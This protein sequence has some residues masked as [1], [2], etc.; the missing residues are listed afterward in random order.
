MTGDTTVQDLDRL[1]EY[2]RRSRGFD[3][4]AYKRPSLQRRIHKRMQTVGV[5]TVPEYV[6]HLEAHPD[7]FARLFD[8][9]LINVTGFLRDPPAWDALRDTVIPRIVQPR[10]PDEP[11]RV[12]SAGSASGEEAYTVAMVLCEAM[13]MDAFR[14]RVKIYATD[15]DEHALGE[16]RQ[17]VYGDRSVENVPPEWLE[18]YFTHGS[19]GG[20]AFHRELR[21][22]VIF[23]R[24]D[25]LHD[26]PIPRVDL[27]V[28][29]NTLM[30]FTAEAQARVLAR[31]SFAL[32]EQ[33]FLF[34]GKAETL[35]THDAPF[36]AADLRSRIFIHNGRV[37]TGQRTTGPPERPPAAQRDLRR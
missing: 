32:R 15:V 6:D 9:I 36:R 3:F 4:G 22:S 31:F 28:C 26:A 33:G 18:R 29:R 1:L 13:G 25:I 27:L 16:A 8:T 21:R 30:Y 17:A 19:S 5:E 7:E 12:W 2:L 37:G 35:I 24:H 34:L 11:I 10:S 23:G 20:W 14:E